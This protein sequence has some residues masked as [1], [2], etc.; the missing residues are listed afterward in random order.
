MR[1]KPFIIGYVLALALLLFAQHRPA[2]AQGTDY[3]RVVDLTH[4]ISDRAPT[5]DGEAKSP[6]QAKVVATVA[7]DGY[8]ARTISLP[9]HFATHMDAPAHFAPTGWTVDQI[10]A[11][12]LVGPLLVID[13]RNQVSRNAD[14]QLGLDDIAGWEKTHGQIPQGGIVMLRTGW[15]TRWSASREYRNADAKG[16]MHFPGYSVNAARFLVEGRNVVALG[17]DTLSID[18]GTVKTFP[19]HQYTLGRNVYQLENVADLDKVPELGATAV[20]APA[21]L[22]GGSGGPVRILAMVP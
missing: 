22:K 9:E 12:R 13:V 5:F 1:W 15:S 2:K 21:K 8:F 17:I 3:S 20:A 6:F 14:Y 4:T 11:D 7:K 19:V 10:P 16:V 18:P